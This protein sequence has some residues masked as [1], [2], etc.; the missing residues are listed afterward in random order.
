[1][2]KIKNSLLVAIS[3]VAL[4]SAMFVSITSLRSSA[5]SAPSISL[6][7]GDM[8]VAITHIP[9]SSSVNTSP[10]VEEFAFGLKGF[11]MDHHSGDRNL[12]ITIR[13]VFKSGISDAAYPDYGPIIKGVKDFLTNYPNEVDYWEIINKRLTLMVLEKTPVISSIT[14]EIQ[15]SSSGPDSYFHSS[16]VT[17]NRSSL[18]KQDRK[19]RNRVR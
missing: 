3:I 8:G 12:N 14:S 16:I 18:S 7:K 5:L 1:M 13:Y 4:L 9:T 6:V 15:V 11:K 19:K 2:N 17:R 10:L